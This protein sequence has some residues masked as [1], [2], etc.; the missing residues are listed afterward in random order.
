M[1]NTKDI[2]TFAASTPLPADLPTDWQ[3]GDTIAPNGAD[4]GKS[5]QYG[6]NYLMQQVNAAQTGVNKANTD[7]ASAQQDI[8]SLQTDLQT[9]QNDIDQAQ[10]DISSLETEVSDLQ[11]GL[12]TTNSNL[13]D[14]IAEQIAAALG[15]HGFRYYNNAIQYQDSNGDWQ[16]ATHFHD[17]SQINSGILPVIRGGT[18]V[19]SL[20][21]LAT[22][23]GAAKVVTG[24]YVG[25]GKYGPSNP[26]IIQFDSKPLFGLIQEV[27]SSGFILITALMMSVTPYSEYQSYGWWTI[28]SNGVNTAFSNNFKCEGT[29]WYFYDSSTAQ[30]QNNSS[31]YTYYYAVICE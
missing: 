25:T 16:N 14:H 19:D 12:E 13:S 17:A 22:A 4:V 15:A 27:S 29:T 2:S 1:D 6:Y 28:Y 24:S 30:Q 9:A 8:S 7:L 10:T 21:A 3:A 31:G 26:T 20:Q 23:L 5:E 11:T 18:G